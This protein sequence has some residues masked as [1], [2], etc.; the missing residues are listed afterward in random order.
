MCVFVFGKLKQ[1]HISFLLDGTGINE[2]NISLEILW[3][4][5]AGGVVFVRVKGRVKAP[6]VVSGS[7]LISRL[8][9]RP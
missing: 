1:D 2:F 5:I 9:P 6:E 7:L 4:V 3:E 8:I